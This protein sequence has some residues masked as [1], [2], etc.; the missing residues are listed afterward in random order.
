MKLASIIVAGLLV[1]PALAATP[2]THGADAFVT[3]LYRDYAK[4]DAPGPLDAAVSPKVFSPALLE[5]I[6]ADQ[7]HQAGNMGKLDHDPICDCQDSDGLHLLNVSVHPK[8][9]GHALALAAFRLGADTKHVS[10]NLV[11]THNGWR[12]DDVSDQNMKS[13]RLFLSTP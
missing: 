9:P 8:S 4:P 12:V 3:N 10:L 5:K 2:D 11:E 13:L 1:S 7:H 6:H